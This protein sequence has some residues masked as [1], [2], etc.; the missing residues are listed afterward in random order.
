MKKSIF[1][2][3]ICMLVFSCTKKSEETYSYT[4]QEN[5]QLTIEPYYEGSYM[6]SGKVTQGNNLVFTYEYEA[7]DEINIADDEYAEV[8]QFEIEPTL[9][10]FSYSD[11]ELDEIKAVYSEYCFCAFFDEEKN[12]SPQGTISGKKISETQ[13]DIAIDVTFYADDQKNISNTFRLKK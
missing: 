1:I 10:A 6:K 9:T 11:N 2:I 8:I 13:W 5:A 7:E 12:T 3:L 4:F